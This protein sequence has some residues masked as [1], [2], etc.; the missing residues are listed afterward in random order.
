MRYAGTL[1]IV[2]GS[3]L[4]GAAYGAMA[5]AHMHG[6]GPQVAWVIGFALSASGAHAIQVAAK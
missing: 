5:F 3:N 2:F 1:L 4:C 6:L